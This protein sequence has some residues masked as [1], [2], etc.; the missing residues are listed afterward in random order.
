MNSGD[1]FN[2]IDKPIAKKKQTNKTKWDVVPAGG[3]SLA[4]FAK[5][6]KTQFIWLAPIQ[7]HLQFQL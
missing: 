5:D 7:D 2:P 6:S 3:T 4:I 1:P